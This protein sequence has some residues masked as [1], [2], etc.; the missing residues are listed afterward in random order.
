VDT[1]TIDLYR[2]LKPP[3]IE[4]HINSPNIA[5]L[6]ISQHLE[7]QTPSGDSYYKKV[8][9]ELEIAIEKSKIVAFPS[10]DRKGFFEFRVKPEDEDVLACFV[11]AVGNESSRKLKR[12]V[13]LRKSGPA[14]IIKYKG[15][16]WKN[17]NDIISIEEDTNNDYKKEFKELYDSYEKQKKQRRQ[18][19][20]PKVVV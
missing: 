19:V 14:L 13:Y 4:Q 17:P 12:I 6:V 1:P 9:N 11:Y 7:E 8:L 20:I 10:N 3:T 2:L 5:D 16:D 18:R 15:N